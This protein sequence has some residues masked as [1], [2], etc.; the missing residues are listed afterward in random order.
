MKIVHAA[1]LHLDSPL[2][3]LLR[4]DGAPVADIR[5]ATRR[6]FE[7]LLGLCEQ[8]RADLLLLAGDLFDG[9]WKDYST[10]LFFHAGLVRL[11]NAGVQ[12][13]L[14]RGN[15][16][17]ASQITRR[18]ELPDGVVELPSNR[19][20]TWRS[21]TLGVAVHG[22]S[23]AR[24][25]VSEDLAAAYPDALGGLV[26]IGL[27]H[28][29]LSGR[30]GHGLYAP[31]SAE[32]LLAKG[33]DY[34]ALG[35]VH[36]REIVHAEPW[37]VFPGNLQGRHARETGAKGASLITVEDG[38][39]R[40]VEHR[41]LDVVRWDALTVDVGPCAD[42]DAVLEAL[43]QSLSQA[44]DDA[45]GRLL[46]CRVTLAGATAAHGALVARAE[47]VEADAR[48]LSLELG[49]QGVWIESLR[50]RTAPELDLGAF[51]ARDDPGGRLVRRLADVLQD[52]DALLGLRD[53]LADLAKKLP[54]E[55]REG[56]DGLRLDDP[57]VLRELVADVQ[58]DLPAR[59]L[60]REE[61]A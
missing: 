61:P 4:H 53:E 8:E 27:L 30:P 18:L 47:Q 23:F 6:A 21:E 49:G 5:G 33:Y 44:L 35:H 7:N 41:A 54:R 12:V 2:H 59:L 39:V 57:G 3:G 15:H 55:V 31:T 9:D 40:T 32:A 58:Q 50:L 34:W 51:D 25:E 60:A 45:D 36:A 11:R 56:P 24:R 37:I 13:V 48:A 29:A 52:D 28:T 10:G 1:D 22:Q 20:G 42:V 43:R 38:R 19:P 16:D 17:A 14:V 26:N 46:A